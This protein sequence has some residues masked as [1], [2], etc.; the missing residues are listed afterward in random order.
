MFLNAIKFDQPI[1]SWNT[2]KVA[3]M[4]AMFCIN[5]GSPGPMIFNQNIGNWDTSNVINMEGMFNHAVLFNQNISGWNVSKV[6]NMNLMF[7]R[8]SSFNQ[9][10]SSWCVQN[11]Y[12]KPDSFDMMATNWTLARPIWGTCP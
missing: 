4:G 1:G 5:S 11:I 10:L 3:N 9:N 12:S 2:S 7:N 8:A 6:T